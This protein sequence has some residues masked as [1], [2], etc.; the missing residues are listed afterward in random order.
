MAELQSAR[1]FSAWERNLAFRY[2]RAKRKEGGVALISIISFVGIT[3]AVAVLIIVM[4]VMNGF[5]ADLLGR[6]LG[7]NGH[8]FIQGAPLSA[9]D[10]DAMVERLRGV[11]GVVQVS[12]LVENQAII[13]GSGQVQGALVRGVSRRT[14]EETK[15]VSKNIRAGSKDGFGEGEY[16]GDVVLLG[17]VLAM[18]LGLRPGDP[19]TMISPSGGSTA[20]GAA[21]LRK[22]FLLGGT[23]NV[24]MSQF[25]AL[26][27][28]MPLE[29]AQLFFG[30]EGL[31]DAIEITV[32]NPDQIDKLKP[33][34]IQ[35]A[36]PGALFTD[37]RDRNREFFDA[38]QVERTVMRLILMFIVLIAA[39]NII[40]GLVM[41]VKNKSRDIAILRTMGASQSAVLR[42]FFMAGASIGLAGTFAGLL[43]GVLF[44]I[45]IGPIQH[46]VEWVTGTRVFD[47]SIYFLAQIPA[48]VEWSEVAFVAFWS[49]LA[50]CLATLPPAWRASKLDPVEALR[51]E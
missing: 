12:P 41:L 24:G 26:Y 40:S 11:P 34:I 49:M 8:A 31:W 36:G 46:F 6:M 33:A 5:R 30:K 3:L 28:Y 25:D 35:A 44:C 42:I 17:E 19:V 10:R 2:L 22:T 38:L 18:N 15:L 1:P 21:P 37:W 13:L 16:G 48:K 9:P 29:Q 32:Q 4:S 39:M 14:L 47:P 23:F 43:L 45:F 51:Y 27:A 20:F 50:A 7:F